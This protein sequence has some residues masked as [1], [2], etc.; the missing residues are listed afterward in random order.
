MRAAARRAQAE[1]LDGMLQER[2]KKID[3]VLNFN[4]PDSL[5]VRGELRGRV[6]LSLCIRALGCWARARAAP[7]ACVSTTSTR[8]PPITPRSSA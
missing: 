1:K 5:L 8:P 3:A 7:L 6:A 4:V 2:G